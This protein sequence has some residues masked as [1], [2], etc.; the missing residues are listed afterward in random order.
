MIPRATNSCAI[1]KRL[2][3]EELD[4]IDRLRD[5]MKRCGVELFIIQDV[6][7][8]G[9]FTELFNMS[10][11]LYLHITGETRFYP[12]ETQWEQAISAKETSLVIPEK[13]CSAD[14]L[15]FELRNEA[16]GVSKI[17]C[18][19]ISLKFYKKFIEILNF[20]PIQGEDIIAR[21]IRHYSEA[22]L[23]LVR[24]AAEVADAGF[25]AA[26]ETIRQGIRELEVLAQMQQTFR[27][28]G[29]EWDP[30]I[31]FG[32]GSN[33]AFPEATPIDRVIEGGD[34]IFIDI[35]PLYRGYPSDITRTYIVGTP[36]PSQRRILN[37]LLEVEEKAIEMSKEGANLGRLDAR[38][39]RLVTEKGFNDYR[40][41]TGHA[42]NYSF[43]ITPSCYADLELGDVI[44]LEPGIYMPGIGGGR[45][46]DEI[47]I[48]GDGPEIITHD[49][50]DP[51]L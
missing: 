2:V 22:E 4:K 35:G 13:P 24:K 26:R 3:I 36:N 20:E 23:K 48:T 46:E 34:M 12:V 21:V 44:C 31:V 11:R 9:F 30:W 5:E 28:K 1:E 47:I 18:D 51:Y 41:H 29:S 40:H 38:V 50:R 49:D 33:S 16:N 45:M 10:G 42:L 14:L 32:S 43:D 25:E 17:A 39:R 37:S 8:L 19:Q 7:K 27:R 6:R 15:E